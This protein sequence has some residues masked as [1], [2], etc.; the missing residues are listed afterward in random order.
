MTLA[1]SRPWLAG[2][3]ALLGLYVGYS[4]T[5]DAF[6]E[7]GP[8]IAVSLLAAAEL[9][10]VVKVV[11]DGHDHSLPYIVLVMATLGGLVGVVGYFVTLRLANL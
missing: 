11:R 3:A 9:L 4:W 7:G 1:A 8:W 10:L 5:F 6:S 2:A